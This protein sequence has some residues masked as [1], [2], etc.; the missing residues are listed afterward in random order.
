MTT[1]R[2]V[3]CAIH[4]PN[5][6]PWLGYFNK[7]Q[8]ADVFVFLD[9][10][11]FNKSG[12]GM[13]CWTN[14]VAIRVQGK[15]AW[16]GCPVRRETGTQLIHTVRIDDR[17][18][19]RRKLLR[20][21]EMNYHRAPGFAPTMALIEPL[22]LFASD[23]LAD[24]NINAIRSISNHMGARCRFHRQSETD[25]QGK[26][27]ELLA[28]L[29]VAVGANAYLAG[30]GADEYQEDDVFDR[31]DIELIHQRFEPHPY[32]DLARFLPGLS[33]IDYLMQGHGAAEGLDPAEAT[34]S[35]P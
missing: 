25:V 19:W 10:V 7:I 1:S 9:D 12:S 4:Q 35:T 8:R 30:G 3:V 34:G 32:G 16:F 27:T 22:L 11:A 33:V 6:F 21:L 18:P 5:F 31:H 13:G 29:V 14:R 23:N 24:F 15:A 2:N 26:S 17:Q 28:A 20:T